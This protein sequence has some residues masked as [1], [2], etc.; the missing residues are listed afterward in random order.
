MTVLE[1]KQIKEVLWEL[2]IENKDFFKEIIKEVILEK[3]AEVEQD[4]E[5]RNQKI[6]AIIKKDFQR[7][8]KVFEALA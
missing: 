3:I 8:K 1:K 5:T 6:E 7:Y 2:M 4:E